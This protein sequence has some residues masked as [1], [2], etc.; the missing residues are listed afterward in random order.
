[1][2]VTGTHRSGPESRPGGIGWWIYFEWFL[3]HPQ[4]KLCHL[5]L[6]K[7]QSAVS[8]CRTSKSSTSSWFASHC[9]SSCCKT[10]DENTVHLESFGPG[11][12]ELH[13][14]LYLKLVDTLKDFSSNIFNLGPRVLEA[15]SYMAFKRVRCRSFLVVPS[16]NKAKT[17]CTGS[18]LNP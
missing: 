5:H 18:P 13:M 6:I 11:L 2:A 12:S 9:S 15:P 10:L 14:I 3:V 8:F 16:C 17:A 1:M 7:L 4:I